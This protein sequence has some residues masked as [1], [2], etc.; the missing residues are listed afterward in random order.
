M[1]AEH[2]G[3]GV[4]YGGKCGVCGQ[5]T[6]SREFE[7]AATSLYKTE[8]G[9]FLPVHPTCAGGRTKTKINGGIVYARQPEGVIE[10]D[11]AEIKR[12]KQVLG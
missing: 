5:D 10:I 4:K 2:K 1:T 11:S 3:L 12:A 9:K 8:D 7:K 6:G